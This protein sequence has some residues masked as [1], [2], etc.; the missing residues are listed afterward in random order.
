VLAGNVKG[1]GGGSDLKRVSYRGPSWNP[2][3]MLPTIKANLIVAG[4][5]AV[6][7]AE[8]NRNEAARANPP[9]PGDKGGIHRTAA[10]YSANAS[11]SE[12]TLKEDAEGGLGSQLDCRV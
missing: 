8:Q 9:A 4:L 12:I 7:K 5:Q 6:E 11:G 2:S 1:D 3:T 10:T